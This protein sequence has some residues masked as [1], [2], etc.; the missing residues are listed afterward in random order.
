MLYGMTKDL[1]GAKIMKL[2]VAHF[3]AMSSK[4]WSSVGV[5][6]RRMRS[7]ASARTATRYPLMVKPWPEFWRMVS[8]SLRKLLKRSGPPVDPCRAPRRMVKVLVSE[9][10]GSRTW[11]DVLV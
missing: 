9:P 6:A 7:S 4:C 11:A 5:S 1:S 10:Q 2:S 3:D 8:K